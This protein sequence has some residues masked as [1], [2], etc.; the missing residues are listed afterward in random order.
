VKFESPGDLAALVSRTMCLQCTIQEDSAWFSS[1]DAA[2]ALSIA[3]LKTAT[4]R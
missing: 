2:V 1:S 3:G 4:D